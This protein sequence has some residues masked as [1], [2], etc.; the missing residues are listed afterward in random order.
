MAGKA[1]EL[2]FQNDMLRHLSFERG[3]LRMHVDYL[4]GR[5][6]KTTVVASSDGLVV[7]ETTNRGQ[8]ATRWVQRLKGEKFLRAAS[9]ERTGPRA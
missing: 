8:A 2:T 4:R 5:C 7:L 6:I 1:T 3:Q 9:E